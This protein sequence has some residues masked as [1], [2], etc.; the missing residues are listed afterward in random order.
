MGQNRIVLSTPDLNSYGFRVMT[1][2]IDLSRFDKNPVM[3]YEHWTLIGKWKD[4]RIE[5]DQLTA[6]PD[7]I[8]NHSDAEKAKAAWDG[9]YINA[10]SIGFRILET[11]EDPAM[12]LPGQKYPTVTKAALMEASLVP[13]PSNANALRLF[14]RD[15]NAINL[16]DEDAVQLAFNKSIPNSMSK[17]EVN[18]FQK[19]SD[20][21]QG[22]LSG[23]GAPPVEAPAPA[24]PVAATTPPAADPAPAAEPAQNP[25]LTAMTDEVQALKRQLAAQQAI[26]LSVRDLAVQLAT[27]PAAQPVPPAAAGADNQPAPDTHEYTLKAAQELR[28]MG[29][30][31]TL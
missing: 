16:A 25:Q 22:Y 17:P 10:A 14:D 27:E 13:V 6:E 20:L 5:G 3:L 7:F 11:S 28:A 29:Y 1:A 12:M 30:N 9:G 2:G 23:A 19:L 26:L 21:L 24:P 31:V 4:V 18:F 8:P 15:G